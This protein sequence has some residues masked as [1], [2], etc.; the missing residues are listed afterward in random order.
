MNIKITDRALRK[1]LDTSCTPERLA[2][3]ISLCG[4]TFDKV[5]KIGNEYLY[6]VEIITNRIDTASAQGI[7]RDASAILN[8]ASIKSKLLNDPYLEK[9]NLY[10]HFPKIFHFQISDSLL[11][12]RFTAISLENVQIKDSPEETQTLLNLCDL[13]P[14]NNA[15]DIT[16]ELTLLYGLPS[17]IFDLDK[18]ATQNLIIRESNKNEVVITLDGQKN[19]LRGGDIVIED[20][21]GR[22]VDLC[23]V[24]GGQIAEVDNYTKNI[25]LIVPVYQP[26][27]VRRTSL[28][29]QKRTLASQIY[30]KQPDTQLCLP[31]LMKAIKLFEERTGARVSSAVYDSNSHQ[32]KTVSIP[33]DLNWV[34][35]FI[36]TSIPTK[37]VTSILESLGFTVTN[38]DSSKITCSTPSWRKFDINIKEDLVEEIARVFGYSKLPSVLPCVNLPPE[39]KDH[40][41]K[42]ESKIKNFLSCQGFNEVYNNSLISLELIKNSQLDEFSHLKLNNALSGDFEYLRTSLVPSALINIKNNQGKSEEPF[43]FFEVSNIYLPTKEKLPRELPK[44]VISTTSEFTQAKGY[45]EL[46]FKHLN[47]KNFKIQTANTTPNY[48]MTESTAEI[49]SPKAVLGYIGHIKPG[50]LHILGITSNPS[51]Y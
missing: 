44:T 13:R 15:V 39:P 4:P 49:R 20:G 19:I 40:L 14:I 11:T 8:Q 22:L 24:M 51:H 32:P 46:L 6:E 35:N 5:S 25:L 31:V 17:H 48:F 10:A 43:L 21:A 2:R 38:K 16:N 26:N 37:T 42:T 41:L 27:K 3:E 12:P 45:L 34:N 47:L 18:L 23:G 7:A 29:H 9:I 36:G 50:V 33:L 28:Y 1:F 30:E